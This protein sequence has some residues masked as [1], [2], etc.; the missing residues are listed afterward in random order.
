MGVGEYFEKTDEEY[1]RELVDESELGL[2]RGITLDRLRVEKDICYD[3]TD[4]K[5][6][7]GVFPTETG[8]ANIYCETVVPR[9]DWGQ[10]LDPD[11]GHVPTFSLP[12]EAWP[13]VRSR[14]ISFYFDVA[15]ATNTLAHW[16]VRK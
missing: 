13:G 11:F 7:G 10:E 6:Y 9:I 8:R 3:E 16:R 4:I 1:L 14:K 15:P 2:E 5:F 12:N